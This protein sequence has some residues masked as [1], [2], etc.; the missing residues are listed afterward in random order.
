MGVIF[1]HKNSS[2]GKCQWDSSWEFSDYYTRWH[3]Y[4]LPTEIKFVFNGNPV[5]QPPEVRH[6]VSC[7][8]ATYTVMKA[9]WPSAPC[10]YTYKS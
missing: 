2:S 1:T 9:G 5:F 4:F 3:K 6:E 7:T 8:Y 10:R